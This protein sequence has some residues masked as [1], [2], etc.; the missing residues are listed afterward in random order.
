MQ[1]AVVAVLLF[2]LACLLSAADAQ[3]DLTGNWTSTLTPNPDPSTIVH[4]EIVQDDQGN[5]VVRLESC[6]WCLFGRWRWR[7][8]LVPTDTRI[9]TLCR[10]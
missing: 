6:T 4:I 5:I 3:C 1:F 8:I 10:A 7:A 2:S 9:V